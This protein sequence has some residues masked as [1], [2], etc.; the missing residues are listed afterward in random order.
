MD[1]QDMLRIYGKIL[2]PE[3]KISEKP[4]VSKNIDTD[5]KEELK[6]SL[7]KPNRFNN[8]LNRCLSYFKHDHNENKKIG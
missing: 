5:L 7:P 1:E 3:P 6:F 4:D 2:S 8:I